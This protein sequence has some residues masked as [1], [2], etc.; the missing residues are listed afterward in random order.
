MFK[1]VAFVQVRMDVFVEIRL[2]N[3]H[4]SCE[5]LEVGF[6]GPLFV[7][8]ISRVILPVEKRFLHSHAGGFDALIG[9]WSR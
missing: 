5:H 4:V 7:K 2:G 6:R 3:P 8:G 1:V 9:V